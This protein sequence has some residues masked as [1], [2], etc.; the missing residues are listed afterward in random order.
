MGGGPET[1]CNH[2]LTLILNHLALWIS[3]AEKA[4]GGSI[5]SLAIFSWVQSG[6]Q[7]ANI[8]RRYPRLLSGA[9]FDQFQRPVSWAVPTNML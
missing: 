7:Y 3:S 8:A 2:E 4:G 5:P 6:E 1:I 9:M